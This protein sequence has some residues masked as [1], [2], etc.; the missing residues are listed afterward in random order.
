MI[1]WC[2]APLH[3]DIHNMFSS[4]SQWILPHVVSVL[5]SFSISSIPSGPQ[6]KCWSPLPPSH[7]QDGMGV[8]PSFNFLQKQHCLPSRSTCKSEK[9]CLLHKP[10]WHCWTWAGGLFIVWSI[11]RN[12]ASHFH[13]VPFSSELYWAIFGSLTSTI[14]GLRLPN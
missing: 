8:D 14:I 9:A 11:P 5:F 6:T 1:Q 2:T 12:F 3:C 4:Q 13:S 10:G 7:R